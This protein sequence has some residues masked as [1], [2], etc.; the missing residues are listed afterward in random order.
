MCS[1]NNGAGCCVCVGTLGVVESPDIHVCERASLSL[2]AS[3]LE[4]HGQPDL[5]TLRNGAGT[6]SPAADGG[7]AAE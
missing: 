7:M 3:S 2:S 4:G 6:C 5:S 1:E